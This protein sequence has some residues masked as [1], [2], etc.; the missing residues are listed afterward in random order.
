MKKKL[1]LILLLAVFSL[2]LCIFV[3]A[4]EIDWTL[5]DDGSAIIVGDKSYEEYVGYLHPTDLFLPQYTF[6][7]S[8][9]L[10][11][12][13]LYKNNANDDILHLNSHE[14]E[15]Q[16]LYVTENGKQSL[17]KYLTGVYYQYSI[18][19]AYYDRYSI[20]TKIWVNNLEGG[21]VQELDVRDLKNVTRYYVMGYDETVT[22]AHTVGAIYDVNGVLYYVNYDKLSNNYFDAHGNF[23][24]LRGTVKAFKLSNVQTGHVQEYVDSMEYFKFEDENTSLEFNSDVLARAYFIIITAIFGFI[25]PIVPIALGVFRILTGRSK[26]PKRWSLIFTSCGLWLIVAICILLTL[27]I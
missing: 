1:F 13:Y 9:D 10:Y 6:Q 4:D 24:Y 27:I 19:D 18:V 8:K 2:T 23:S 3:S 26:N 11:P 7:Y 5:S 16:T 22:I 12:L 21:A 25:L 17:D 15:I 14:N 20:T